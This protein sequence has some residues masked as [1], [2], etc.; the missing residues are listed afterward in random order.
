MI[1]PEE[2]KEEFLERKEANEFT[3]IPF[4]DSL[5]TS[6]AMTVKDLR[7]WLDNFPDYAEV[8]VCIGDTGQPANRAYK[9]DYHDV[10]I[11]Y[12]E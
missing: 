2:T 8:Y 1:M 3:E 6:G 10:M 5:Q 7:A 4:V 9:L 12:E 11:G